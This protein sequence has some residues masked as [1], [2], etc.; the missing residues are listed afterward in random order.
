MSREGWDGWGWLEMKGDDLRLRKVRFVGI[1][2]LMDGLSCG[3]ELDL[4]HFSGLRAS[5][6]RYLPWMEGTR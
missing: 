3:I 2:G 1:N 5:R 6:N 4:S